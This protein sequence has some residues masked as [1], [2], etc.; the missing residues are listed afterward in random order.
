MMDTTEDDELDRL[1]VEAAQELFRQSYEREQNIKSLSLLDRREILTIAQASKGDVDFMRTGLSMIIQSLLL[2][3][4]MT[5]NLKIFA[6][7]VVANVIDDNV[8]LL[9]M[10]AGKAKAGAPK[11]QFSSLMR[12]TAVA[13][14]VLR[15]ESKNVEG[16]WAL[17]AD[18]EGVSE[19]QVKK[20]WQNWKEIVPVISDDPDSFWDEFKAA[21]A[22]AK[23]DNK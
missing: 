21:Q 12:A 17:V 6:L 8:T 19:S 13:A 20:D 22:A 11:R 16:A 7:H 14:R 1:L 3:R 2:G 9:K 18:A 5:P 23:K 4:D 10:G 15:G